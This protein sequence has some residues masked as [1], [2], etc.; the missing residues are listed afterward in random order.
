[1]IRH[2]PR[3]IIRPRY[4]IVGLLVAL[5]TGV[6]DG[7]PIPWLEVPWRVDWVFLMVDIAFW[8]IV[9][10]AVE[11]VAPKFKHHLATTGH[12]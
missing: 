7:L 8:A 6:A 12:G 4:V 1:M 11:D 5:V 2:E 10:F 9:G 3:D